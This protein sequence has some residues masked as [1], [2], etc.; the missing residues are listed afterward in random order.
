MCVGAWSQMGFVKDNDVKAVATL[1]EVDAS[2]EEILLEDW[3][4]I[5]S[6]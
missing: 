4:V 5:W 1:P 6:V 2:T 3:D